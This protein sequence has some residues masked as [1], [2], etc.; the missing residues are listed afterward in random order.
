MQK[1]RGSFFH[2][3]AA[4]EGLRKVCVNTC[5]SKIKITLM[6]GLGTLAVCPVELSV[7]HF[8]YLYVGSAEATDPF[9]DQGPFWRPGALSA[10]RGPSGGPRHAST[11]SL[12]TYQHALEHA[13]KTTAG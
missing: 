8:I 12:L 13:Q 1:V 2:I 10:T 9:G 5:G 3:I 4:T 6:E 7:Y 11:P